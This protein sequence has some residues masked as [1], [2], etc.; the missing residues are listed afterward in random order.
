M[1]MARN[2][3]HAAVMLVEG[4]EAICSYDRDFHLIRGVRGVEP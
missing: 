2:G 1:L 3:L 4:F